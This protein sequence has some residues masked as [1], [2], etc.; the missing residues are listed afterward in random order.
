[1]MMSGQSSSHIAVEPLA[2]QDRLADPSSAYVA[3]EIVAIA[4]IHLGQH[5]DR[6]VHARDHQQ[7][8]LR[9]EAELRS[10]LRVR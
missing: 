4:C 6:V 7:C 3:G 5:L 10:L 8:P 1:M 9:D 2:V